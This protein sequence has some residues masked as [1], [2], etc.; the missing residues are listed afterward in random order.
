MSSDHRVPSVDPADPSWWFAD[1]MK[2]EGGARP[3]PALT[4]ETIVDVAIVGGGFTGLWTA[5]ALKERSPALSIALIEASLCGSGASGKNGGKV[6]GY[7]SALAGMEAN[8]GADGALAVARAGT[9]AQDAIR[10]FATAPGRDVW[11]REAGN[12]R[13]SASV[14]QDAKISGYVATAKRLGVPDTAQAL[15]PTEVAQ[16][17]KSP[18]FRGGV[19]LPEGANVH[20][21]RLARALRQAAIE[22]GV[23]IYEN[24]PMTG[25]EPGSPNRVLTPNGQIQAR[26]VVLATNIELARRPEIKPHVTVFSSYALMTEPAPEKLAAAGWAG[27]EGLADLRMFVHY[28]RKT[29][30]GRLLM[31]SGSG[32][33]SYNGNTTDPHLTQDRPSAARAEKALRRLLPTFADVAIAK[34]WGGGIDISSDRLPFF[35][36]LPGTRIHYGCGYSGHGVNPTYMGGQCLASLVLGVKDEWSTLPLCTRELPS[37]PPEP[38]RTVGGRLVRWGIIG[39]EEADERGMKGSLPMQAAAA[40]PRLFGLRIGTR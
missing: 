22:A 14:G 10:S 19:F 33:I 3:S 11:W 8:I 5:L 37:L 6:H 36:T 20:P 32:P 1:A 18:V 28:F 34:T 12:M 26:E 9:R 40:I 7:W 31:G 16:R 13:V 29:P 17:C 2:A 39:C 15:T 24:T 25:V 27:E 23:A 21:A 4:G 30:D 38:F 35:R